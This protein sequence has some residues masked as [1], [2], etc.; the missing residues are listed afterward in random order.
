MRKALIF[1]LIM[2]VV[3]A[4]AFAHSGATGIVKERMDAMS[5]IGKNVKNIFSML[6]GKSEYDLKAIANSSNQISIHAEGFPKLFPEGST[7]HPS[8][9]APA[10][11][12]RPDDFL[13]SAK[14]LQ[15]FANELSLLAK[16]G[17]DK[18]MVKTAF[19]KVTGTCKSCHR[20]FRI[21]K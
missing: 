15:D 17:S 18:T 21:K 16:P 12:K 3:G 4:N 19:D 13:K 8:E 20:E 6:K 9:A 7:Q 5:S 2:S 1:T 10:I 14:N 11:W